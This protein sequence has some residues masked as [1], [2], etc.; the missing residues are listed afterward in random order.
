MR[1]DNKN[2]TGR[3]DELT[4][5]VSALTIEMSQAKSEIDIKNSRLVSLEEVKVEKDASIRLEILLV[6][7]LPA[8][9]EVR[10]N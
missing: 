1:E 9:D 3:V 2:F 5:R 8:R 7:S 4:E 6:R 10:N